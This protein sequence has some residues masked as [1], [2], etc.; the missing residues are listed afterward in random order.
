MIFSTPETAKVGDYLLIENGWDH[1]PMAIRVTRS[2]KTSLWL[3]NRSGAVR[4]NKIKNA[5]IATQEE[6]QAIFDNEVHFR[7]LTELVNQSSRAMIST[8]LRG[9]DLKE[10]VE[11]A[12][13]LY[14]LICSPEKKKCEV[15]CEVEADKKADNGESGFKDTGILGAWM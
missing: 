9:D 15:E 12:G 1:R 6:C 3:A 7:Q 8:K 13:K 5:I 4:R 10:A 2:T 14:V 11:L